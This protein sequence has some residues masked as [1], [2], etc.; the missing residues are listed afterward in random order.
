MEILLIKIRSMNGSGLDCC[1]FILR[2]IDGVDVEVVTA[3][4]YADDLTILFRM[5]D[6]SVW[7]ILELLKKFYRTTGLEVNTEKTQ[8]MITGTNE[9][10]VGRS[11]HGIM[12]VESV[13]ILGI[14]IDRNLTDLDSNW[15]I[16][17]TN[18]TRIATY[19]GLFGLSI[20]GRVMVAKTYIISQALY[21]MGLLPLSDILVVRIN[22]ILVRYIA[23]HGRPIERRRQLLPADAGGYGMI[24]MRIMNV[25]LKSLWISRLTEVHG[26]LD[27]M[28]VIMLDGNDLEGREVDYERIGNR[29]RQGGGGAILEDI[30]LRWREFKDEFY[31]VDENMLRAKLFDNECVKMEGVKIE[32]FVFGNRFMDLRDTIHGKSVG[33]YIDGR[34]RIKAK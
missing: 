12:V 19:W 29:T 20:T 11:V 17:I 1:N 32:D 13:K 2:K 8:L 14:K 18:M 6:N 31:R 23:G 34:N 4:A 28:S 16:I 25:C 7:V 3:E 33:D 5:S 24:D 26:K 9:W 27:Y 22:E 21:V 15:E 10:V 30:L